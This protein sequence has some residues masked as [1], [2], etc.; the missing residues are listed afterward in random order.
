MKKT[1]IASAIAA[2]VAAPVAFADVKISGSVQVEYNEDTMGTFNDIVFT[3]SDDLGNGMTAST[4][5]HLVK[6]GGKDDGSAADGS[7]NADM[8]VTIAGDF[9]SVTVGRQE[10]FQE[11]VFDAFASV[12][13]AHG[14]GLEG[15]YFDAGVTGFTRDEMIKYV[16]PSF[17][18]LKVGVTAQDNGSDKT[19]DTEA[20][21][22]YS[23]NGLTVNAGAGSEGANDFENVNVTYKMGD[24]E[25][26]AAHRN[27][28]NAS[29]D[30]DT[31]YLAAKYTMGANT[32][33]IGTV[34]GDSTDAM[35]LSLSH[36]LSKSTNVYISNT[37]PDGSTASTTFVGV[38]SAF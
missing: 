32:L 37:N 6:D 31:T 11:G 14:G 13:A 30:K 5:M 23:I 15:T 35:E 1:I 33:A 29:V 22:S 7:G 34:G 38:K 17:N 9:G 12:S 4:K 28:K 16:S 18:G 8:T 10:G 19:K 26:R 25:L 21:V 27:I 20:M 3:S 24:L 2:V 36:A